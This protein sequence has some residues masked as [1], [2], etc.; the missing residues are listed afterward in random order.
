MLAI[1]DES[2]FHS[3]LRIAIIIDINVNNIPLQNSTNPTID[4]IFH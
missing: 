3:D 2:K 1:Y 4:I